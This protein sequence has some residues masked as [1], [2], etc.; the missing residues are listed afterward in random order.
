MR[1]VPARICLLGVSKPFGLFGLRV[2]R[3]L[4]NLCL[5]RYRLQLCRLPGVHAAELR[6]TRLACCTDLGARVPFECPVQNDHACAPSAFSRD[7]AHLSLLPP[8][9]L[10]SS[11]VSPFPFSFL[12][13]SSPLPGIA[14]PA[15]GEIP[16]S[17]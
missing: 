3:E 6:S 16:A 8:N 10:F 5:V 2:L 1:R 9:L 13:A 11:A 4:R 15:V 12:H 17:V 14:G 7:A